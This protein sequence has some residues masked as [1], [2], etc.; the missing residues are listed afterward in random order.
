MFDQPRTRAP[1]DHEPWGL[2][3]TTPRM[4]RHLARWF[5]TPGV[6]VL[7]PLPIGVVR[8]HEHD[9]PCW[10]VDARALS[11]AQLGAYCAFLCSARGQPPAAALR[12]LGR[13]PW[14]AVPPLPGIEAVQL[15]MANFVPLLVPSTN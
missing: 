2:I 4:R 7:H 1:R 13:K 8:R 3:G 12:E 6:P 14:I 11:P 5:G 10:V 9:W 15:T